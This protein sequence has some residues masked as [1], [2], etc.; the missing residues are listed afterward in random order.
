MMIELQ[1][2]REFTI[3]NIREVIYNTY[4]VK[5]HEEMRFYAVKL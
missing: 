2:M 4:Y 5:K 3:N 1:F